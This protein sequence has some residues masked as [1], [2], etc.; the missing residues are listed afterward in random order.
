VRLLIAASTLLTGLTLQLHGQGVPDSVP[1]LQEI[2]VTAD[3]APTPLAHAVSSTTIITGEELRARGVVFVEDALR[4][5]PGAA[6]VPTGSYGGISSLFLRGGESDHVKVLVDGVAVNQPGGAFNF[7]TLTTDNVDRIE[8]V[9]GPVSVL[10]GSD[11]MTGVVQIF[12]RRGAGPLQAR[13]ATRAGSHGTWQGEAGVSGG[14]EQVSYSA[15]LSRYHTEGTYPFNSEYGSTV[16]SG[17]V[18]VRPDQQTELTLTARTG[19][20]VLHFPTDFAGVVNDSNQQTRENGTTLGLELGRRFSERAELRVQL[21][22]HRETDGSSNLP[23]S[24]GDTLGFYSQSQSRILRQSID[25]RGIVQLSSRL[26]VTAGVQAEFEDLEEFSTGGTPFG[27]G[28]R[29]VGA[30]GQGLVTLFAGTIVN[31]GLRLDDNQ[32]FGDHVTYRIGAVHPL[33]NGLRVRAS[34][35]SGFKEPS[36]RQNYANSAFEVGNPDLEPEET[37]SWD[38][39]LEQTLF[40]G[41]AT[42]SANYFQQRFRN[43]IQYNAAA[44]PGTPNYENVGHVKTRG[45][46]VIGQLRRGRS[47]TFG[48]SYTYLW[49]LVDDPGFS[50]GSGDVFVLNRPLIR[51]P[52]HSASLDG[53]ARIFDRVDLALG[54]NYV[55]K[56]EDVDFRP[57]PSIRTTLPDYATV[58]TDL[59]FDIVKPGAG[60]SAVTA[61]LRIENLFDAT[62]ETVVGFP[63]RGRAV[64]AGGS[65]GF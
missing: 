50:S 60:R 7:G 57:F 59:S 64:F 65:V 40:R 15:S 32:K 21:G 1:E 31:L 37:R 24:P 39:G 26:R 33:S 46:E 53:R 35:G 55:G 12:T 13:F 42:L 43:L 52:A 8:V 6:V 10:Y 44:A 41:A 36:I 9:R 27:H 16:G 5:V 29:D 3:R 47:L 61:S 62:Y 25:A 22:S 51:R 18:T 30:Y 48:G 4:E 19:D 63:G 54:V 49:S 11:A 56:R 23:D 38:A 14:S 28:R 34:V 17:A 20:N 45:V 2:V 58:D